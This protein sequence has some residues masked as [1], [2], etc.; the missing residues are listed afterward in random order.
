[1]SR[2]EKP[3]AAP[4]LDDLLTAW[5]PCRIDAIETM[6]WA[7]VLRDKARHPAP[8]ELTVAGGLRFRGNVG[9]LTNAMIEVGYA[10]VAALLKF[11]G[12]GA[13]DGFVVNLPRAAGEARPSADIA[14]DDY[15][16]D[17]RRL[18]RVSVE[19]LYA[20][21]DLPRAVAE[22]V[23]VAIID[24]ST[25]CLAST[26]TKEATLRE[27]DRHVAAVGEAVLALLKAHVYEKLKPGQYDS[28]RA[29]TWA[30]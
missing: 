24:T 12:I 14:I 15:A 17:G 28:Y 7:L 1:M 5:L 16:V 26:T 18:D 2:S 21:I 22:W 10:H 29:P 20:A 30:N 6:R 9:L 25:D 8:V 13:R 4:G 19:Q 11:I 23:V 3:R 27:V